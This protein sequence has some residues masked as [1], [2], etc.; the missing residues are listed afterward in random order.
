LQQCDRLK[1]GLQQ[2]NPLV[3]D[4]FLGWNP[5]LQSIGR[6]LIAWVILECE[7]T[8]L[9]NGG[10]IN[11]RELLLN[12]PLEEDRMRSNAI[13]LKKCKD[14]WCR[15]VIHQLAI[16][17]KDSSDIFRNDVQFVTFNYDVSLE[18]ALHEGLQHIQLFQPEDIAKFLANDR[19]MHVY[20]KVRENP[21]EPP[22]VI[23][24]SE[25][26]RDPKGLGGSARAQYFSDYKTFLDQI[27][28]AS[29]GI[30]VIDPEDKR[31]DEDTI[32]AATRAIAGASRVYILGYGFDENNSKI[33]DLSRSL[34]CQTSN[35]SVMF[36][37][38]GNINRVNKRVARVC[39][40]D[41]SHFTESE[42]SVQRPRDAYYE[43][44]IRDVYEALEL[45]FES[46][47]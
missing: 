7:Y 28:A 12:S 13:D 37:N 16:N 25:Q 6:L 33:I 17:C 2:V 19:I 44:S 45:D 8:H 31:T 4:Y 24:W 36:T 35:K 40:G 1:L 9:N 29:Q 42:P 32:E 23:K 27:Y 38:Y 21:L 22:P 30:R 15:F 39:Y 26:G 10:N 43:R 47:D 11:R 14:D 34:N 5:K 20:G 46:F 18:R 3:I 41:P